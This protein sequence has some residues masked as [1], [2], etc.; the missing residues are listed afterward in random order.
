MKIKVDQNIE[1]NEVEKLKEVL[2][3]FFL[4]DFVVTVAKGEVVYSNEV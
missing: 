1:L 3:D 4:T 2:N